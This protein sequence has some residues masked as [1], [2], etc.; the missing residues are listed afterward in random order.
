[1]NRN[2]HIDNVA[3]DSKR[4][5]ETEETVDNLSF[6]NQE[7]EE[8]DLVALLE[9]ERAR[10]EELKDQLQRAQAELINFRRRMEQEQSN[11]RQRAI[12]STLTRVLPVADDFHRA[13]KTLPADVE[14]N[15]WV[16]GF[17]LI[18]TNLRK[19]LESQGVTPMESVGKPFDP[20]RHE[21]VMFDEDTSGEHM[22]VEE[23]QRGYLIKDRVLRPA[24][25]RVGS[26]A[27]DGG[28]AEDTPNDVSK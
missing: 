16:E 14:G 23:F 25:V 13:I 2:E 1:M 8:T 19:A 22:V 24:M 12:E 5:D 18:E 4:P 27:T 9:Q 15:G 26:I 17:R 3:D 10:T 7:A 21:A 6:L 11:V 20:A 28:E